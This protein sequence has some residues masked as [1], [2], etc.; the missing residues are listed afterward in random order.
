MAN[1]ILADHSSMRAT[2]FSARYSF[3]ASKYGRRGARNRDDRAR[4]ALDSPDEQ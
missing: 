3:A 2:K 1:N 4:K